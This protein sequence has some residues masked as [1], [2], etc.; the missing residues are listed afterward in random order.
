MVFLVWS[1]GDLER[2]FW[3]GVWVIWNGFLQGSVG[4]LEQVFCSGVWVIWNGFSGAECG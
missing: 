3:C 2:V 1:V 4:D